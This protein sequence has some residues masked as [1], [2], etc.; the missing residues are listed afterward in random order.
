MI[1][2]NELINVHS[3]LLNTLQGQNLFTHLSVSESKSAD[4]KDYIKLFHAVS[5]VFRRRFL[6]M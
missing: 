6:K 4:K 5:V 2:P 1:R 3:N